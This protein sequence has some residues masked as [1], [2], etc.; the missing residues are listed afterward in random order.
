MYDASADALRYTRKQINKAGDRI[1]RA[2]TRGAEPQQTDLELLNEYRAWHQPT[3]EHC[4]RQLVALFH[5]EIKVDPDVIA[6][7][8]RPLK[9]VQDPPEQDARHRWHAGGR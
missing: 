2:S 5:E 8:G 3:L 7:T 6:I 1:R 4:Q 9:T